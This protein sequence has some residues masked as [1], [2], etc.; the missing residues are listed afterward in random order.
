MTR[1]RLTRTYDLNDRDPQV[2]PKKIQDIHITVYDDTFKIV[3]ISLLQWKKNIF[4]VTECEYFLAPLKS[5]LM[6]LKAKYNTEE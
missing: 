4:F 5:N 3:W 1:E 2:N 6:C